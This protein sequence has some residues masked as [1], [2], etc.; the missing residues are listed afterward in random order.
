[1]L[2]ASVPL[3]DFSNSLYLGLATRFGIARSIQCCGVC[4][5]GVCFSITFPLELTES[6]RFVSRNYYC[7]VLRRENQL[8][9]GIHEA[10]SISI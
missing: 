10:E 9:G 4:Y 8:L 6:K 1:M 3:R 5:H 2:Y 7:N